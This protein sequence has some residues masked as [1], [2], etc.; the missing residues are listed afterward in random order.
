MS[1][2]K[3][4]SQI[5][6]EMQQIDQLLE[7]YRDLLEK[8]RYEEPDLVEVTAVAS[9][10]HSFYNGIE[11]IFLSIAKKIDKNVPSGTQW[12]RDLLVQMAGSTAD[13]KSVI[14]FGLKEKLAEY[15]GFRHFYRHSY[16]FSLE[17]RELE[18]L[19]CPIFEVW[20]QVKE[21]LNSFLDPYTP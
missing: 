2:D 8:C 15:L 6:F 10:L 1:H 9:V 7:S 21:E 16:S 20:S 12:H 11:N 5:R 19:A 4:A 13:R 17:W 14:T 18:K 3:A